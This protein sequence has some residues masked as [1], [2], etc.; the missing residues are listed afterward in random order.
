MK[1]LF[2]RD[3][4]LALLG[5]VILGVGA[6]GIA[7]ATSATPSSP[8]ATVVT[9]CV[10]N[11]TGVV[12]VVSS[13]PQCTKK[14]HVL[15]LQQPV[16]GGQT[17]FTVDCSAGQTIG[18]VLAKVEY[19]VEPVS[20]DV[21]GTCHEQV[22]IDRDWVT[23]N[24]ASNGAGISDADQP[25]VI[26][27]ARGVQL[28][29]LTISGGGGFDAE[30]G[31]TFV[32]DHLH[33]TGAS[34]VGVFVGDGASGQV[35]NSTIDHNQ[36]GVAMWNTG[37]G[38]S[39]W[40][41]TIADNTGRG[42]NAKSGHITL[43][44]TIVTRNGTEPNNEGVVTE[45]S[46]S[47]DIDGGEVSHNA[48]TGVAAY[49]ASVIAV[50]DGTVIEDNGSGVGAQNGGTVSLFDAVVR[51]NAAEGVYGY[52]AG[53]IK[54]V[55]ATIE[56]NGT[57][58]PAAGV[59]LSGGSMAEL[60]STTTITSNSGSGVTL[61]DTSVARIDPDT[62]I[63][64]NGGWGVFCESAPAVAMIRVGPGLNNVSGNAAGAVGCQT[65]H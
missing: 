2:A 62:T 14:E 59:S 8:A 63:S 29:G 31:A 42:V 45:N 40:D 26:H 21:T 13:T 34:G 1:R 37:G 50:Y 18:D 61:G 6:G 28:F 53:R 57:N 9:T 55:I 43:G 52:D 46:G 60:G 3:P 56:G 7:Y 51:N 17:H 4:W 20:I 23:L 16:A 65:L 5:A 35:N 38:L 58:G 48:S 41:S 25:L 15:L 36:T 19:G 33:V 22:T 10:N 44:D 49:D 32:A 39:I 12:R 54:I 47:I 24:A 64:D 30:A 11:A 27:G